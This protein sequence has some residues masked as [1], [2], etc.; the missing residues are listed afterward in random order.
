MQYHRECWQCTSGQCREGLYDGASFEP[1][2]LV[3]CPTVHNV[4]GNPRCTGCFLRPC[5]FCGT[6]IK[7]EDEAVAMNY[8]APGTTGLGLKALHA[9]GR[10]GEHHALIAQWEQ[11]AP[12]NFHA[13]C[14]SSFFIERGYE[15]PDV[16]RTQ[17][18]IL[19][20]YPLASDALFQSLSQVPRVQAAHPRRRVRAKGRAVVRD[21]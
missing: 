19:S 18:F 11:R 1:V 10:S 20:S 14:V 7:E 16:D 4:G 21:A 12:L 2:M 5:A 17:A 8:N 3:T 15:Y 13:A 6:A 9:L